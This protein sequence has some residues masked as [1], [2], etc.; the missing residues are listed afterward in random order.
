MTFTPALLLATALAQSGPPAMSIGAKLDQPQVG[1]QASPSL[2]LSISINAN[3]N[4]VIGYGD[5]PP[6]V[7]QEYYYYQIAVPAAQFSAW[8]WPEQLSWPVESRNASTF[9]VTEPTTPPTEISVKGWLVC[10]GDGPE[11]QPPPGEPFRS[12]AGFKSVQ[13]PYTGGQTLDLY[14][15]QHHVTYVAPDN[16]RKD[17]RLVGRQV[18]ELK[19]NTCTAVSFDERK[20]FGPANVEG[21]VTPDPNWEPRSTNFL[22]SVYK[23]GLFVGNSAPE[24]GGKDQSRRA[25]SQIYVDG[26]ISDSYF[27]NL[28]TLKYLGGSPIWS[29]D[30]GYVLFSNVDSQYPDPGDVV[31]E[32]RWVSNHTTPT[33]TSIG[34]NLV[35]GSHT[36]VPGQLLRHQFSSTATR[37][38]LAMVDETSNGTKSWLY[39]AGKA[40]CDQPEFQQT[41][42]VRYAA[43]RVWW[44][45]RGASA[46]WEEVHYGGMFP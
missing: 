32:T 40:Y 41:P 37:F 33:F 23:G 39:F 16:R 18:L 30:N 43:P 24:N 2:H 8:N 29:Q 31:W 22:G 19:S 21:V 20:L 28:L 27:G 11:Y 13:M 15:I 6:A 17:V 9:T 26:T 4:T 1:A 46:D 25:R 34:Q 12:P 10:D 3:G 5:S 14:V 7:P 35:Y 42:D 36:I 44:F 38:G 45:A